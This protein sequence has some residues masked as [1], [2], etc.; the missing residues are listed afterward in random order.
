[1]SV[2]KGNI[3]MI[4]DRIKEEII[5]YALDKN[6]RS[7]KNCKVQDPVHKKMLIQHGNS[8]AHEAKDQSVKAQKFAADIIKQKSAYYACYNGCMLSCIGS[9]AQGYRNK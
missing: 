6:S 9:D 8:N 7:C 2:N 3:L 1:M 4:P 5:K